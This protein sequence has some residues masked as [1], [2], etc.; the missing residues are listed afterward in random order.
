[1]EIGIIPTAWTAFVGKDL[2]AKIVSFYNPDLLPKTRIFN[3]PVSSGPTT[4]WSARVGQNSWPRGQAHR[5]FTL[6]G[7]ENS[8]L[9]HF[10][11]STGKGNLL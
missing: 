1:M 2:G 7:I 5:S 6:T 10:F 8:S 3:R 11:R 9:E 4:E